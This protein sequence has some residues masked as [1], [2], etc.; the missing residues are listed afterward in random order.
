MRHTRALLVG[1]ES[2]VRRSEVT[3]D[4]SM[5]SKIKSILASRVHSLLPVI[6]CLLLIVVVSAARAMI[7]QIDAALDHDVALCRISFILFA[8]DFPGPSGISNR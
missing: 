5:K 7:A 2:I 8:K 4:L 3:G 1:V 6:P